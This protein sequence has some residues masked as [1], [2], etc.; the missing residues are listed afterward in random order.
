[1]FINF[2]GKIVMDFFLGKKEYIYVLWNWIEFEVWSFFFYKNGWSESKNNMKIYK[3]N[4][5]LFLKEYKF[6]IEKNRERLV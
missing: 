3:Y 4:R 5:L 1:M 6:V 2:Y